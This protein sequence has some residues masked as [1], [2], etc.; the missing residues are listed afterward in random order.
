MVFTKYCTRRGVSGQYLKIRV[1]KQLEKI[2]KSCTIHDIENSL[3]DCGKFQ[4]S[5]SN[6]SA[7]YAQKK[8]PYQMC[9]KM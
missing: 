1:T 4:F 8:I 9:N 2:A 3:R 5:F 7:P 6:E